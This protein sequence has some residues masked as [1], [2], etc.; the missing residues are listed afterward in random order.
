MRPNYFDKIFVYINNNKA[1]KYV[2]HVLDILKYFNTRDPNDI[3]MR[4]TRNI[5]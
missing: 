2:V 1:I 5:S 4:E 3:T